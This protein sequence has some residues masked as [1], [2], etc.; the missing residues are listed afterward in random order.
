MTSP[1]TNRQDQFPFPRAQKAGLQMWCGLRL[2]PFHTR[3]STALTRWSN[4]K[5]KRPQRGGGALRPSGVL[6]ETAEWL[7]GFPCSRPHPRAAR[8]SLLLTL[9]VSNCGCPDGTGQ[10]VRACFR[11]QWPF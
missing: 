6:W 1:R 11:R 7:C 8:C 9:L 2:L 10:W 5:K 3:C 4:I